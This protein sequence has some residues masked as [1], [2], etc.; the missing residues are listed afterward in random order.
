ME[1][2][3]DL[4]E[5]Q[6]SVLSE[7]GNIGAG[8]AATSL[9]SILADKV[10]MTVPKLQIIDVNS[11]TAILG[12]PEN[13]LAGILVNMTG[14]IQGMLLFLFDKKFICKL[15]NV[16]L[17]KDID[18]FEN[19]TDLDMS[20]IMEIGNIMAG[21]YISAISVLTNLSIGLSTPQLAIDMT[22]AILSYPAAMF[23]MIG[24]KLLFIEENFLSGEESIKSHLLIM[25]EPN[26]LQ[27]IMESLGVC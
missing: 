4:S 25:P 11:M 17:D 10:S 22:G 21:S 7:I 5:F 27:L 19:I 15:I 3:N 14:D 24:E 6:L 2:Y 13:E 18:K 23:G 12:G 8:N 1:I 20:A 16:L 26:S 9:A